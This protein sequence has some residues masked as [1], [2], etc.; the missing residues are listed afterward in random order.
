[1]IRKTIPIAFSG[2]TI[3]TYIAGGLAVTLGYIVGCLFVCGAFIWAYTSR[4]ISE[5]L[6]DGVGED[7]Q[8][9]SEPTSLLDEGEHQDATLEEFAS[10][11]E[12][13]QFKR[14]DEISLPRLALEV[15]W[16]DRHGELVDGVSSSKA[17]AMI[18]SRRSDV[19]QYIDRLNLLTSTMFTP[20][21]SRC[22][23]DATSAKLRGDRAC[24][25]RC[26]HCNQ[27]FYAKPLLKQYVLVE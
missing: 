9:D 18:W 26:H 13:S 5:S 22:A 3:A 10:L 4:D 1:M 21:C 2:M 14:P 27:F 24:L 23:E 19:L 16:F 15:Y 7:L 11:W 12:S 8:S 17:M 6:Y 25:K 20:S